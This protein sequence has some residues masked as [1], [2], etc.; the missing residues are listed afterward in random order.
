MRRT[1]IFLLLPVLIPTFLLFG[2]G[3]ILSFSP[4]QLLD[5]RAALSDVKLLDSLLFTLRI[6]FLSSFL[7]TIL[8]VVLAIAVFNRRKLSS[9]LDLSGFI[10]VATPHVVA[11][12]IIFSMLSGNGIL[13]RFFS[14]L[15]VTMPGMVMDE[16]G[17]GAIWAYVWKG[18]PFTAIA[19]G[20][21]IRKNK[22]NQYESARTLGAN[23]LQALL[24]S[25][26]IPAAP[27]VMSLFMLLFV[28]SFGAFEIPFLLGPTTPRTLPVLAWIEYNQLG[29]GSLNRP[30][31][32]TS[33]ISLFSVILLLFYMF[34]SER[35]KR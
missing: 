20:T 10:P 12:L 3:M 17:W 26:L 30:M 15:G 34:I 32:F 1:N 6:S 9:L 4:G 16:G 7:S 31:P 29:A 35:H 18:A 21:V 19:L 5:Y 8:G 11:A 28:F 14:I 33:L 27:A 25:V 23:H 13:S 22:P 24:H 2:L